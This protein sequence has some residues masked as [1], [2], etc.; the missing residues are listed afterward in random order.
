MTNWDIEN[1]VHKMDFNFLSQSI[2]EAPVAELVEIYKGLFDLVEKCL[3]CQN[4]PAVA[5]IFS[6][7]QYVYALEIV[8]RYLI[9]ETEDVIHT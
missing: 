7:L 5:Y 6:G 8:N 2:S 4:M 3:K 9:Q 1:L